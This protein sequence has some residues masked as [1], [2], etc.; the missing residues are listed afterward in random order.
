MLTHATARELASK[1]VATASA[2][3][4]HGDEL[5]IVDDATL[6]RE[7]GWVF[8]YTSRLWLATGDLRYALGGNAPLLVERESGALHV[9]GTAHPVEAYVAAFERYGHPHAKEA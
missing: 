3:L 7:W 9:L 1:H 4:E 2:D 5:V 6:E 8:F